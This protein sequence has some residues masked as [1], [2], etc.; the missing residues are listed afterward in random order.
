M[1]TKPTKGELEKLAKLSFD[2]FEPVRRFLTKELKECHARLVTTEEQN[3]IA[4]LQG[5]AAFL[6]EFL[7]LVEKAREL[8]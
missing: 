4:R 7:A 3:K 5:R 1:L 2:E 8:I 6:T